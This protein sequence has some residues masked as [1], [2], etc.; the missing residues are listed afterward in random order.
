MKILYLAWGSL[1]WNNIGL[2]LTSKWKK[3]DVKLPL[4]FTRISDNGKGRLTLVID[5]KN[6]ILNNIWYAE[7]EI[8]NLN[9]AINVLK[10]REGTNKI[11]IGYINFE[12]NKS[13]L[14]DLENKDKEL[15]VKT[16][17]QKYDA[18]IWVNL[19]PNW[20]EIKKTKYNINSA[21]SYLT[22]IKENKFLYS[23]SLEYIMFSK[24]FGHITTPLTE[25]IF[26]SNLFK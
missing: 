15:L 25:K 21:L 14:G 20:E 4:N 1:L 6:G 26:S 2:N 17:S 11:N 10:K 8:N 12:K 16:F 22:S 23:K 5:Y 7:T 18:I 9:E 13:R 3:S 24:I 19:Q